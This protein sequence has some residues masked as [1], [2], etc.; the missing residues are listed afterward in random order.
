LV[1]EAEPRDETRQASS[2][3]ESDPI[4]VVSRS[5]RLPRLG[6]LAAQ[7]RVTANAVALP[8]LATVLMQGI[9]L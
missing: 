4:R 6:D 5:R 9:V 8:A 2:G 1:H 7:L 3:P